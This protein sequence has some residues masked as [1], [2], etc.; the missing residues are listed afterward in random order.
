METWTLVRNTPFTLACLGCQALAMRPL[1]LQQIT[2]LDGSVVSGVTEFLMPGP[3]NW[4]P[5]AEKPCKQSSIRKLETQDEK[6]QKRV[7]FYEDETGE[8]MVDIEEAQPIGEEDFVRYWWSKEELDD[9]LSYTLAKAHYH[10][11]VRPE[12][13]KTVAALLVACS[14][15]NANEFAVRTNTAVSDIVSAKARGLEI[16][17]TPQLSLKRRFCIESVL[18]TQ[19]RLNN[20]PSDKRSRVLANQYERNCKYAFLMARVLADGDALEV[21]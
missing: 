12:F 3:R 5:M 11:R 20:W 9:I 1:E 13:S 18:K 14:R 16:A 17:V 2:P 21:L 15:S 10:R 6:K 4:G 8:V 7:S 19:K